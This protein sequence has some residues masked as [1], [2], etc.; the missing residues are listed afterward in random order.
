V[1]RLNRARYANPGIA[2]AEATRLLK[3]PSGLLVTAAPDDAPVKPGDVIHLIDGRPAVP[4]ALQRLRFAAHPARVTVRR[5][6][7]PP[8]EVRLP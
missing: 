2:D 7:G 6:R 4:E 3:L 1:V 8:V 5:E